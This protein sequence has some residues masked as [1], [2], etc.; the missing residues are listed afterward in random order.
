MVSL[1]SK[2]L[3]VPFMVENHSK[4][5]CNVAGNLRLRMCGF[6]HRVA[7]GGR[8]EGAMFRT[9]TFRGV[10]VNVDHHRFHF[11][12]CSLH[13]KVQMNRAESLNDES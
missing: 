13:G 3:S 8:R 9:L 6:C 7:G 5:V 11:M 1:L 2:H 12:T 10:Q 4:V